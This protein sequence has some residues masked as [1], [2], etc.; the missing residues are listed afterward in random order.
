[1]KGEKKMKKAAFITVSLIAVSLFAAL[2]AGAA[3]RSFID[4]DSLSLKAGPT[5][6]GE[7]LSFAWL[8]SYVYPKVVKDERTVSLGVRLASK[9]NAV[10]ASFDFGGEKVALTSY[11]GMGWNGIYKISDKVSSGLHVVKYTIYNDKGKIQRTVEFFVKDSV[12]LANKEKN[13]SQGEAVSSQGWPL[14]VTT[15]CTAY[16]GKNAREIRAGQKIVGLSKVSWYKAVFEDGKTGW[17]PATMVSEPLEEYCELGYK[18]Y[19]DRNYAAAIKHY[20]NTIEIDPKFV[21]G[22]FWLAKSYYRTG[23]LEAAYDAIMEAMRLAER[24]IDSK[25]FATTLAQ[26]Y[27]KIAH[28]KFRKGSYNQAIAVYQKILDLKPSSVLSWIELGKCYSKL[29]FHGEAQSAW[30]EALKIEPNNK[31][32]HALLEIDISSP[33]QAKIE[34]VE[35]KAEKKQEHKVV[36]EEMVKVKEKASLSP[37]SAEDSLNIVKDGKTRKGTTIRSAI[38]S[39]ISLTKSLGTPVNEKGWETQNRGSDFIVRYICEQGAGVIEAFEWLVDV[40]T[41]R[42]SANNDN[43]RLLMDRW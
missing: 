36:I 31:T 7:E 2:T 14:T 30:R 9:V 33:A 29:G 28:S 38:N 34:K 8:E 23:D 4:Q 37:V 12:D 42:V 6:P 26:G 27:F 19:L 17:L 41:R 1:M 11:D 18:A 43:A 21:R 22:H 16:V 5:S 10:S 13:V 39:V 35:K 32:I 20:K 25:V 24:D 3:D 40:K 15:N